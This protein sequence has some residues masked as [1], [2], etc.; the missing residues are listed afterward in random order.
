MWLWYSVLLFF[1]SSVLL[2]RSFFSV[3]KIVHELFQI[4]ILRT[5]DHQFLTKRLVPSCAWQYFHEIDNNENKPKVDFQCWEN[6]AWTISN[7]D[8]TYGAK[9]T[10]LHDII[11]TYDNIQQSPA[12]Y[13]STAASRRI[14]KNRRTPEKESD[15]RAY[16]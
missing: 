11:V 9:L 10:L 5:V 4:A 13:S 1:C 15:E 16:E 2:L 8:S 6:H 3:G 12:H 7:S 14:A